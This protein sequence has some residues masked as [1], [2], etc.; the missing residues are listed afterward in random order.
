MDLR[1]MKGAATKAGGLR[2][3]WS[4]LAR[5]TWSLQL[6]LMKRSQI[7]VIGAGTVLQE[8]ACPSQVAY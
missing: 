2:I 7:A 5:L 8:Q 1:L 6:S 4:R 3:G